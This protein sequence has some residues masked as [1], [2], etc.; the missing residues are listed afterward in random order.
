LLLWVQAVAEDRFPW[1]MKTTIPAPWLHPVGAI[2]QPFAVQ[3]VTMFYGPSLGLKLGAMLG[4]A[5]LF[6]LPNSKQPA[7]DSKVKCT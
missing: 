6:L 4:L 7:A 2:A 5:K 1:L 3:L